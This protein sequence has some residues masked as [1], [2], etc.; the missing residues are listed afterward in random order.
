MTSPSFINL[1]AYGVL[2]VGEDEHDYHVYVEIAKPVRVCH[3]CGSVKVTKWGGVEMVVRDLPAQGKRAS[4]YI[5]AQRFKYQDCDRTASEPLP[6][7]RGRPPDDTTPCRL[8]RR[9]ESEAYVRVDRERNGSRRA[10]H[11]C[12]RSR[13]R[14][15]DDV[16]DSALARS[17]R[18]P[19]SSSAPDAC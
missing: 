14:S 16:R 6:G 1:S 10:D 19:H 18:Y 12:R 2:N 3:R 15:Q 9:A 5:Q 11:P 8:G 17:R 7:A 4:L 13:T